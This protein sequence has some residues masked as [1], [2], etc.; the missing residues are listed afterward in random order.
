[1][2]IQGDK[3]MR[4]GIRIS[5]HIIIDERLEKKTH[6]HKLS[7]FLHERKL[8]LTNLEKKGNKKMFGNTVQIVF[9]KFFNFFLL[10]IIF[11]MFP[12]RFDVII[13]KIIF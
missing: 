12:D 8:L 11:V 1:M 2:E 4:Q 3:E 6:T 5:Q 7:M 10:K 13:S 9:Q